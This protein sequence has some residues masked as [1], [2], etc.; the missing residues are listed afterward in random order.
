MAGKI[1]IEPL[2][3]TDEQIPIR[4]ILQPRGELAIIEDGK[5]F[6]H[7]AYFTI[8]MD[9]DYFRG[10]HYHLKKLEHLYLIEGRLAVATVDLDTRESSEMELE[11]GSRVTIYPRCAHRLQ[12]ADPVVRVI[13]YFDSVHD[14]QDDYPFNS[15][16]GIP[17]K[18][19]E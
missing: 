17:E 1:L 19:G 10:G 12:A 8:F 7:L 4:R 9:K 5:A 13:E 18:R 11:A 6:K 14:P 16:R 15:L 2:L 3:I